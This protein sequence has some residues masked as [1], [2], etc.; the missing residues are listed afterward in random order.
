M[1]WIRNSIILYLFFLILI[2]P[3][4]INLDISQGLRF[5][6]NPINKLNLPASLPLSTFTML[7]VFFFNFKVL[8]KF[9]PQKFNHQ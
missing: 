4:F 1:S 8:L 9:F 3:V 5:D 6:V 7:L 2:L